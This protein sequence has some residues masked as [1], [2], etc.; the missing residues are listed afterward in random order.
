MA[1]RGPGSELLRARTVHVVRLSAL[2]PGAG[3]DDDGQGRIGTCWCSTVSRRTGCCSCAASLPLVRRTTGDRRA[4][5]RTMIN[6][7]PFLVGARRRNDAPGGSPC[8]KEPRVMGRALEHERRP[9]SRL[10]RRMLAVTVGAAAL[11]LVAAGCRGSSGSGSSTGGTKTKGGTATR[12]RRQPRPT[13]SSRSRAASSSALPTPTT[14]R[15]CCTGRCTGSARA[16]S[17][18]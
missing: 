2:V 15:S 16:A 17:R 13:T 1:R 11:A 3:G 8:T 6:G 7:T 14:S 18:R 12:C 5:R 9:R 4:E 10:R